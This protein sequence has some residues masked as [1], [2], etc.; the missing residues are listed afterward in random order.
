ML[1]NTTPVIPDGWF[2]ANGFPPDG[3][4]IGKR[5]IPPVPPTPG[6]VTTNGVIVAV[7]GVRIESVKPVVELVDVTV[8]DEGVTNVS[9]AGV[10]PVGVT[11]LT[12]LP[13]P[14]VKKL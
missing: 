12:A 6:T 2:G 7:R 1:G 4:G 5:T 8:T 3:V 11:I 14:S 9:L 10:A 13:A